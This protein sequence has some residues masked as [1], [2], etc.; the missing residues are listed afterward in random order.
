MTTEEFNQVVE[1]RLKHQQDVLTAKA[2]E[3]ARGD[4][5]SNF[6][7]A[8]QMNHSTPETALWGFVT[9]HI[10]A[11]GD[12]VRDLEGG[13]I[14]DYE[15]WEEKIGDIQNY[16]TLLD[17]LVQER[18]VKHKPEDI[19]GYQETTPDVEKSCTDC[20]HRDISAC[21]SPCSND[22]FGKEPHSNWKYYNW[23]NK[24]E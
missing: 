9:K 17:A 19:P 14:Q 3:Y 21:S 20:I 10:I 24:D 6:K 16:M 11:L 2:D 5:L 18:I 4:R 1:N 12:F 8:G 15:R 23:E 13:I 7:S 22:C